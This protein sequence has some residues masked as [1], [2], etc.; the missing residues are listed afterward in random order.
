MSTKIVFPYTVMLALLG[1]SAIRAQE[2]S[3]APRVPDPTSP[4]PATQETV[5]PADTKAP[6]GLSSWITYARP[7]CCGHVGA[8]GP[9]LYELYLRSGFAIPAE[10]KIFGHVLETGWLIEGGGRSLFFNPAM[11][12]AWNIDLGVGNIFNRSQRSDIKFPLN[13]LVPRVQGQQVTPTLVNGF[14]ASIRQ[15]NRTYVDTAFGR[16]WYLTK[17]ED[18]CWWKWR[19]G[20]DVGGRLGSVKAEFNETTHRTDIYTAI[21]VGLHTDWEL[22]YGCCTFLAGFRAEWGYTW[23][24]VLQHQ[25]DGDLQ[26]VN[27][28]F[29]FGVRF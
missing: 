28:L 7:D 22:P 20:A 15:L 5:S 3:S 1:G 23:M 4:V 29:T 25:N 10:G 2:L 18:G 8:D 17:A 12:A 13:I 24:D 14:R 27:L 19:A 9:I 16:E 21:V 6:A 26:D 11:D